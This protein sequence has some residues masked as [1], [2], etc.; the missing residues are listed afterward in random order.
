MYDIFRDSPL[1]QIVRFKFGNKILRYQDEEENFDLSKFRSLQED[2]G[3]Q[4]QA[5]SERSEGLIIIDWSSKDDADN[6]Q[7]WSHFKRATVAFQINVYT[8][9][10]YMASAIYVPAIEDVMQLWNVNHTTSSLGLALYVLGYGIGPL[11]WSPLS[12]IPRIGRNIPYVATFIVFVSP[13]SNSALKSANN[14]SRSPWYF[15]PPL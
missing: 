1:G 10:V 12:E 15:P 11:L 7:N 13:S 2:L 6:P 4:E 3:G 9:T 5:K 8:F 14:S